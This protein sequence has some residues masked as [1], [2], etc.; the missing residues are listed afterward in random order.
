MMNDK[1][2]LM[3]DGL[4]F[5]VSIEEFAAY[6][7]GNLSD[8]DALR[9]ENLVSA[10]PKMEEL[11][12]VSDEVDEDIQLYLQD[13]FAYEADMATLENSDFDIPDLDADIS[14]YVVEDDIDIDDVAYSFDACMNYEYDKIEEKAI[15]EE[16]DMVACRMRE[17][18]RSDEFDFFQDDL[19]NDFDEENSDNTPNSSNIPFDD[20][21]F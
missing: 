15:I 10:D 8:S 14:P 2:N 9:V 18:L 20:D 1:F 16:L 12:S 6:L 21:L 17:M 7:D 4:D 5:S 13:S 19:F 11:L 3:S